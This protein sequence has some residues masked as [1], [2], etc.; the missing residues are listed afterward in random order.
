MIS[1]KNI[2]TNGSSLSKVLEP[3]N[4]TIKINSVALEKGYKEDTYN[5]VMQC[6]GIALE[7][8]EGFYRDV[9]DQSLGRYEGQV[10]RVKSSEWPYNDFILPNG[11]KIVRDDEILKFISNLC[12]ALESNWLAE[13]DNKFETIEELVKGFNID[14]P[15]ENIF[16]YTCLCGKE[17]MNK[18]GYLNYDLFL[19]KY[20]KQGF[21]FE[22]LNEESDTS[23]VYTFNPDSHINK[24]KKTQ[25]VDSFTKEEGKKEEVDD[26]FEL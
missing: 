4:K 7:N 20:T 17:Y 22:K 24:M 19:P 26:G 25:E 16:L 10:G 3:G 15:F 9:K 13:Q 6:E 1:T 12:D 8:F 5:I 14:A 21:P 18:S 11:N 23:N 2:N